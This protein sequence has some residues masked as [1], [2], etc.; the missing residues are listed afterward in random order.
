M[1][2]SAEVRWFFRG[3]LPREVESWFCQGSLWCRQQ[4]RVDQ[5]LVLPG[6]ATVGVKLR[7]GMFEIKGQVDAPVEVAYPNGVRGVRACWVKWSTGEIGA[8]AARQLLAR[9]EDRWVP[10]QK[11]RLLRRLSLDHGEP[12]EIGTE[13]AAPARGCGIEVTSITIPGGGGSEGWSLGLEGFGAAEVV[14]ESLEDAAVSFFSGD[15]LPLT[16]EVASSMSYAEW[17]QRRDESR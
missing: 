13:E 1:L 5:Y 10:V 2:V 7:E 3:P 17:L 6:C 8:G 15:P 16:L 9:D 11:D 14:V 4:R 12:V